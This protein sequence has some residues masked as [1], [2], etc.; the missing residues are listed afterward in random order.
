M[1]P[2]ITNT[3]GVMKTPIADFITKYLQ[4][5]ATR[6]HMPGHKGNGFFGFEGYDSQPYVE[7]EGSIVTN[8]SCQLA[9]IV[10]PDDNI[11]IEPDDN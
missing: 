4:S 1:P 3:E 2:V 6:L 7:V 11:E 8:C 10:A 5:D 9:I